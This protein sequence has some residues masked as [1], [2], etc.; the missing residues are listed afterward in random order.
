M[1]VVALPSSRSNAQDRAIAGDLLLE[2]LIESDVAARE[3]C[4]RRLHEM[5]QAPK[6]LLRFLALDAP[7][8]A[9]IILTDNK[10]FDDADLA[11]VVQ[12]GGTPHRMAVA[13]RRDIGAAVA[14]AIGESGDTAAMKVLLDNNTAKLSERSVELIVSASRKAPEL[15]PLLITREELRPA[16]ALAMFWWSA[17][18]ERRQ[19]L[20]RFSA[21][22]TLLLDMC[23]DIFRY[24]ATDTDP[25]V[26]K[27]LQVIE[28]RQ[29]NRAALQNSSHE[30]LEAAISV[31]ATVK[32]M[33]PADSTEIATLA[34]IKP[35]TGER[36]FQDPGGEGLAVLCKATG[37]KRQFLRELWTALGRDPSDDNAHF[38][39]VSEVYESIAVAKAQTVLRYWNWSLSSAFSPDQIEESDDDTLEHTLRIID[40]ATRPKAIARR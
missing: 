32:K 17:A 34:G 10:A 23:A 38:R 40:D 7:H 25:V 12:H 37:L 20:M 35:S 33:T 28:R 27:T 39:R 22:R 8:V 26:R 29:R 24:A 1:D 13:L 18:P 6:R 19:I 9:K 31:V 4:A 14:S 21:E 36:I 5:S 16:H 15:C 11:Y 3:L 30:S 2:I